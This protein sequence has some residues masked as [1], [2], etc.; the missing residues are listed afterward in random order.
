MLMTNLKGKLWV[1]PRGSDLP[2]LLYLPAAPIRGTLSG[3]TAARPT[4]RPFEAAKQSKCFSLRHPK[5]SEIPERD[6]L[7]Y[8]RWPVVKGPV[9]PEPK[10]SGELLA[11]LLDEKTFCN[12]DEGKGCKPHPGVMIR[13]KGTETIDLMFCFE[14][15]M[16]LTFRGR[17]PIWGANF[18]Y[19]HNRLLSYF[20][21]IFPDD[22]D[23]PKLLLKS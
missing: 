14:C 6:Y 11:A 5:T 16:L 2:W 9:L 22:P 18:D 21:A 10:I 4:W 13:L 23:L 7:L 15:D 3:S 19:S 20:I 8:N 17:E 1:C 12:W